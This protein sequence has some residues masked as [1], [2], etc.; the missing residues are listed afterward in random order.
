MTSSK[1]LTFKD[2]SFTVK[3]QLGSTKQNQQPFHWRGPYKERFPNLRLIY[4]L[5]AQ[6]TTQ[7]RCNHYIYRCRECSVSAGVIRHY[8]RLYWQSSN[9][10]PAVRYCCGFGETTRQWG[11]T[12]I[13]WSTL[14]LQLGYGWALLPMFISRPPS[15][16]GVR[17]MRGNW[18][19]RGSDGYHRKSAGSRGYKNFNWTSWCVP[20]TWEASDVKQ[21]YQTWNHLCYYTPHFP[22][23]PFVASNYG[24]V[25]PHALLVVRPRRKLAY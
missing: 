19:Y 3:K 4:S 5:Q 10:L 22:P 20:S 12:E 18:D 1:F 17:Y 16:R 21:Y 6:F 11:C 2:K 14:C 8:T 24:P 25:N 7:H 9:T 23:L 15:P 13:R